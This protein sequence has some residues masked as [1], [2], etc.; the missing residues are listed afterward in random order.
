MGPTRLVEARGVP[1]HSCPLA[2]ALDGN[3]AGSLLALTEGRMARKIVPIE[4]PAVPAN[5]PAVDPE[6]V[7]QARRI[8][9]S[10]AVDLPQPTAHHVAIEISALTVIKVL[11]V[12]FGAYVLIQVWP[13][14]TLLLTSV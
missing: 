14:L 2:L 6:L 3:R 10:V 5:G 1:Y 11:G 12:I 7:V 9:D 13:L 8:E 4:A